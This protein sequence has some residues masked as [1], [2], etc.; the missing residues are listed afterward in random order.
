MGVRRRSFFRKKRTGAGEDLAVFEKDVT[1]YGFHIRHGE[2][3]PPQK[4]EYEEKE[5]GITLA[6]T[7]QIRL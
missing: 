3:V 4:K 7:G 2:E 1:I 5:G 6:N